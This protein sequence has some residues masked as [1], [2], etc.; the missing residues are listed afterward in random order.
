MLGEP[1][2]PPFSLAA[3]VSS[4]PSQMLREGTRRAPARPPS[5]E[6][7]TYHKRTAA[8]NT[9]YPNRFCNCCRPPRQWLRRELRAAWRQRYRFHLYRADNPAAIA[10]EAAG[11][12]KLAGGTPRGH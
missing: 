4:E 7:H 1:T 3:F 12:D 2:T 10:C 6:H 11:C 9:H 8:T 5:F